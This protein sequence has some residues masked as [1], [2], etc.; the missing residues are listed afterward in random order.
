VAIDGTFDDCQDLVKA[1]FSDAPF[2]AAHSLSAVNSINWARIMAQVVYY[3]AA[4]V[5]LGAP[6][7]QVG[8]AVPTGNFGNVY[9]AH[10]ARRMGLPIAELVIGTNRND[11]L[12]RFINDGA[13]VIGGVEPSLSPS[14]DI[15]V[16]SNFERLYFELKGR[17]GAAVAADFER[18]RRTGQLPASAEEWQASRALFAAH[19]VDDA[20]TSAEIAR[21]Y[22]GAG[23]LLDPHSAVAV[24]AARQ[25]RRDPAVP[26]VALACA[27]PAKFPDAVESATGRRPA[28]PDR[29]ADLMERPERLV[30]LPN[31]LAA[32]E[33]FVAER[34][35]AVR[36]GDA[37]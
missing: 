9:A 6:D 5:A 37:A 29:L 35:G 15:Q 25:A 13:M 22:A 36:A 16:S 19:R 2:R 1:M 27:H 10:V 30:T 23:Q 20:A 21:T 3:V 31:D 26:M 28:L 14:M 24:A 4:A 32:V 34:T 7:R 18:F 12:A 11:I 8:F 33:R 17:D